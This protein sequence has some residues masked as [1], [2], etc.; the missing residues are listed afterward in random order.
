MPKFS[1]SI[2]RHGY[3]AL[4]LVLVSSLLTLGGCASTRPPP[5]VLDDSAVDESLPM[6]ALAGYRDQENFFVKYRVGEHVFY[7]GG[8]WSRRVAPSP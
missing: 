8:S 1:N 5:S 3:P 6:T 7:G 4:I 2:L